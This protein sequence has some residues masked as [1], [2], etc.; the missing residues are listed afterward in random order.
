MLF[1]FRQT[2]PVRKY[3]FR[4]LATQKEKKGPVVQEA[5]PCMY[6]CL[7]MRGEQDA[8]HSPRQGGRWVGATFCFNSFVSTKKRNSNMSSF[9]PLFFF[10]F[11]PCRFQTSI[12]TLIITLYDVYHTYIKKI[13]IAVPSLSP[14]TIGEG[15]TTCQLFTHVYTLKNSDKKQKPKTRI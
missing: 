11:T 1:G 13:L 10:F 8:A 14:L 4:P 9:A 3:I 5:N 2:T 6:V 12:T 7:Y 15:D